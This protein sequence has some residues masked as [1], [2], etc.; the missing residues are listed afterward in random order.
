MENYCTIYSHELYF[1]RIIPEIQKVFPK[2]EISTSVQDERKTIQV[3]IKE[4]LFKP[5]K[6]FQ[7]SYRERITP[8]YKI[9]EIDSPLTQ[10]L[11]GMAGFVNSLP[12]TNEKVKELLLQK[13]QTLNSEL[14]I[15]SKGDLD[16]ELKVLTK[17]IC[18]SFDGIVFAQPNINISKSDT[19]HFLNKDLNLIL[20]TNGN[21]EI[22]N[23][24]VKIDSIYFDGDQKELT[25][26]QKNRKSRSESIIKEYQVKL[27]TNLPCIESEN[28]T[29]IRTSKEIAERITLLA[30]TNMVAFNHISAEQAIEYLKKYDLLEK[31]TQKELSFLDNP[32][33]EAKSHETWK[34]ECIWVL[35]WAL[36]IIED[37]GS[38]NNLA[39]L[40]K[41]ASDRYPIGKD[42]DPNLFINSISATRSKSEI[43]DANDL[44][45][46]LD[47]ACVDARINETTTENMHPGVVY[48]RHY[49]LNWLVGYMNQDWDNV[50]CD[51]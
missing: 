7:I 47:W 46:R 14:P 50:S 25:E 17:N 6:E 8:S 21:C 3:S 51:T 23:L 24:E 33:E 41:I 29:I 42:K 15:L 45:Y 9:L 48:E 26:D 34:C 27:N 30:T 49:A 4:G 13:I 16:E 2:G 38:P 19:Q 18:Q 11:S 44:Y 39:D 35:S 31:A 28:D 40:N 37:L 12:N 32:T 43:L 20:D 36:E 1:E 5:K 10:N 22:E